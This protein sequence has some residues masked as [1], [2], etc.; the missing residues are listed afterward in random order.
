VKFLLERGATA[1]AMGDSGKSLLDAAR[2]FP[3]V[4]ALLRAALQ[5]DTAV[6]P[7]TR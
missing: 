4:T 7:L 2:D 5:K 1:N 3:E 6:A